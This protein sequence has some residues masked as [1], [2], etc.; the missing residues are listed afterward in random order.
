MQP[1]TLVRGPAPLPDE[2]LVEQS[3]GVLGEYNIFMPM[4]GGGKTVFSLPMPMQLTW[5]MA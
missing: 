4:I 5:W 3:A 1:L 2:P